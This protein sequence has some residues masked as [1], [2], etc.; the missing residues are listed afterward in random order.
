[1]ERVEQLRRRLNQVAARAERVVAS[2]R[3]EADQP[4]VRLR[5]AHVQPERL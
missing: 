5:G 3:A 4:F 1:M 2:N